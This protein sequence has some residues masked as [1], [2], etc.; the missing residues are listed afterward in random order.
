MEQQRN[1]YQQ[2]K[3]EEFE[4]KPAPTAIWFTANLTKSKTL[5]NLHF[6]MIKV[7]RSLMIAY[8]RELIFFRE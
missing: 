7:E 8:F 6:I 3:T 4:E 1:D 2:G 5:L